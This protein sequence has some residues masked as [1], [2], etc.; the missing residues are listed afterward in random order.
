LLTGSLNLSSINADGFI[1]QGGEDV[2]SFEE[3]ETTDLPENDMEKR[4]WAQFVR[5][6]SEP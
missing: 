2:E 4:I 1:L 3:I 6:G 5:R